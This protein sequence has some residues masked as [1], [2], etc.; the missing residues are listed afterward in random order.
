MLQPHAIEK[1]G[2]KEIESVKSHVRTFRNVAT[3]Q[4]DGRHQLSDNAVNNENRG[5]ELGP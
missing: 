4:A 3:Q 5:V 2:S 1:S